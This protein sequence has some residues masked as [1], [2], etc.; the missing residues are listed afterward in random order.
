[1]SDLPEWPAITMRVAREA[2]LACGA[3]PQNPDAVTNLWQE[4]KVAVIAESRIDG[5]DAHAVA[6]V[7]VGF[8]E[9]VGEGVALEMVE[10]DL[11]AKFE[12]L[13]S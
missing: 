13:A 12:G 10:R 4:N 1:M 2:V 5:R 3:D 11:R 7:D 6:V 9:D 8:L